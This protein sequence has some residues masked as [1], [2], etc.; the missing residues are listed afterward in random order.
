M[1]QL[2]GKTALVTGASGGI[3]LEF[4][5]QLAQAGC[6][7]VLVSRS[8]ARLDELAKE[9][10]SAHG[11]RAIVH[12]CDL[13]LPGKDEELCAALENN[14][15]QID[16]LVNNAGSGLVGEAVTLDR[17]AVRAMLELNINALSTLSLFCAKTMKDRKEGVIL[18]VGSM[19]ALMPVPY[20]TAYAASKSYVKNFSRALRAELRSSSVTVCCLLPGFVKTGFDKAAGI[21]NPKYS[22]MSEGFGA[23]AAFVAK[24][25]IAQ[26]RSGKAVKVAGFLN[27]IGA[28]AIGLIPEGLLTAILA[29]SLKKKI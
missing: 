28:A 24:K 1:K 7:L 6:N 9:L 13:S 15:T 18:N 27:S 12:A 21:T 2:S 20:F 19:V 14:K 10:A 26:I 8:Q 29:G 25:G 23:T 11:I 4:A 16:I 17:Q 5:R 22:A 3:G